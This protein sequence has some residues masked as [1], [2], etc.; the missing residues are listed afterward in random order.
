MRKYLFADEAGD[1]V[2]SRN[3]RNSRYF[4]I[5]TV[6]MQHCQVGNELLALR[7]KMAWDG[8]DIGPY[9]HATEDK[10]PVRDEVFRLFAGHDF[11]VQAT[12]MEKSKAQPQV[13]TSRERFYQYG[14]LYHAKHG[15]VRKRLL[16]PTD[17]VLVTTASIAG[18]KEQ[19]AFTAGVRD[20]FQQVMPRD[21]W[22]TYFCKCE[23]DPCLQITDYCTWA[24][25]RK[26]EKGDA[27]SYNLIREKISYEY[28]LWQH[29]K[30][31]YY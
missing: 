5:C 31:N 7:R 27:R 14:W 18:K 6:L 28:E 29:G 9:F 25:Q 11:K 24:I 26:W 2:F 4:I 8:F 19:T 30:V 3:T 1:F 22:R 12:I 17:E 23:S 10:Q 21:Q 13:K 16:S 20:V 15:I